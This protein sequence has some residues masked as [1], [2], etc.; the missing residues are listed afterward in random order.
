[1]GEVVRVL[2]CL[3][4]AVIGIFAGFFIA[5]G[6]SADL[7]SGIFD[8][9]GKIALFCLQTVLVLGSLFL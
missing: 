6:C 4:M 8:L 9:F 3:S 1:M 7:L 5:D 2:H